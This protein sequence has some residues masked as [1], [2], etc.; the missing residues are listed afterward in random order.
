MNAEKIKIKGR[1]GRWSAAEF[2]CTDEHGPVA[3]FENDSDDG[4]SENV[5]ARYNED[6]E[7]WEEIASGYGDID[8]ILGDI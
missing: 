6:A 2:G 8:T 7:E 3:L 5:V 4:Y 1:K